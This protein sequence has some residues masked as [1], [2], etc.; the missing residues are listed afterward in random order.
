V[1][2]ALFH[3]FAL[4]KRLNTQNKD[5]KSRRILAGLLNLI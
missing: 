2:A 3:R 5:V 4:V 1:Y